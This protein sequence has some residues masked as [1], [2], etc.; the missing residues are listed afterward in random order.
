MQIGNYNRL[1]EAQILVEEYAASCVIVQWQ[2]TNVLSSFRCF[3]KFS[4]PEFMNFVSHGLRKFR[5]GKS[6]ALSTKLVV[7]VDGLVCWRHLYDNRRVVAVYYKSISCNPLTP[8]LRFV[9]DLLYSFFLQLT[10]CWLTQRVARSLCG[11]RASCCVFVAELVAQQIH[12]KWI[13]FERMAVGH[14]RKML[15]EKRF[16]VLKLGKIINVYNVH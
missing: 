8:A 13:E 4:M 9:V 11:G 15:E 16:K 7:V 12:N 5:H 2:V 3:F 6:I 14:R 10:R 1:P